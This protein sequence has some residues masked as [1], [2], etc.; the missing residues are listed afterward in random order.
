MI[1]N[2][3]NA[4]R[5]IRITLGVVLLILGYG[6]NLPVWGAVIAYVLGF[7]ALITGI[8]GFCPAWK[9][10]GINTCRTSEKTS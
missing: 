5:A 8:V 2:L 10:L 7:V 6:T 4:E 9:A 3:G 1:R